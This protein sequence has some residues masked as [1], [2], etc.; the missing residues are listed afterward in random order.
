[1]YEN[2]WEVQRLREFEQRRRFEREGSGF[3]GR[4]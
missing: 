4:K 1:L 3:G 2:Y